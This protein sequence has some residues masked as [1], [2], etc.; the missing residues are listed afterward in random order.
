MNLPAGLNKDRQNAI[1]LAKNAI[2]EP[3]GTGVRDWSGL[4]VHFTETTDLRKRLRIR[5][6][7]WTKADMAGKIEL[8]KAAGE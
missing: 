4:F 3:N 5:K 2:A 1:R 6:A 8:L 7:A